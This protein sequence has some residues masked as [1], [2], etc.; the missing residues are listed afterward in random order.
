MGEIAGG[1]DFYFFLSPQ[2][3]RSYFVSLL[4]CGVSPTRLTALL[5]PVGQCFQ[6]AFLTLLVSGFF[7]LFLSVLP[8]VSP[9]VLLSLSAKEKLKARA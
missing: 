1:K 2:L 9:P 7:P 3:A 5:R 4:P 8:F 6:L